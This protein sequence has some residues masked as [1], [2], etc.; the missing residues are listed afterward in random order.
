[1]SNAKKF[2]KLSWN[3]AV[4]ERTV[5]FWLL[6][7]KDLSPS[8]FRDDAGLCIF[9]QR[10]LVKIERL[11]QELSS[12]MAEAEFKINQL[13]IACKYEFYMYFG[14]LVFQAN[15]YCL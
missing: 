9:C 5:L 8:I 6:S 13:C 7:R 15:A 3:S 12:A 11:N 4:K 1:M 14:V 2:K 10:L